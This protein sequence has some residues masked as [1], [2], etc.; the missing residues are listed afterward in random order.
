MIRF[1]WRK[2]QILLMC[3][4]LISLFG[5]AGKRAVLVKTATIDIPDVY[6]IHAF[7]HYGDLDMEGRLFG[8]SV[9]DLSISVD[10]PEYMKGLNVG[11]E[12]DLLK[13]AYN[14]LSFHVDRSVLPDK[15]VLYIIKQAF[16]SLDG[17]NFKLPGTKGPYV[18]P[19]QSS[20]G[21]LEAVIDGENFLPQQIILDNC[22]FKA[23]FAFVQVK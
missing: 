3:L 5:C 18:L 23:V 9:G 8:T 4:C 14:G 17:M 11:I 10:K 1:H 15:A 21:K 7:I 13:S 16:Q 22:D 6:E 19:I 2:L 12:T 20:L